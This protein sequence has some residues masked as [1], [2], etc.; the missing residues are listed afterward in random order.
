M[1]L[2]VSA[3]QCMRLDDFIR[4][5]IHMKGNDVMEICDSTVSIEGK[6]I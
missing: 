1:P 5:Q 2:P 6:L 3:I 4:R